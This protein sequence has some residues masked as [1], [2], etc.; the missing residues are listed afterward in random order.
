M[1]FLNA[2]R[3]K[4]LSLMATFW[5][6]SGVQG[7]DILQT[8]DKKTGETFTTEANSFTSIGSST[9]GSLDY[10]L[11]ITARNATIPNTTLFLCQATSNGLNITATRIGGK[12]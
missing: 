8:Q 9:T 1:G 12:N 10:Q 2:M 6:L 7:E 4:S 11:T 5:V 3:F